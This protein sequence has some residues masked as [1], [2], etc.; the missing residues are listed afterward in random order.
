MEELAWLTFRGFP[1]VVP[2]EILRRYARYLKAVDVRLARARVS[3][4]S[5]RAKDARFAPYW[6]RYREALKNRDNVDAAALTRYRWL[7]EEFRLQLFAP[8]LKT[9]EKVSEKRLDEIALRRP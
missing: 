4:A 2:L 3:P 1:K 8:E 6:Q 9:F 7:L 5:D